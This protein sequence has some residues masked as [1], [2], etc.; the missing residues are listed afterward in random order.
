[1]SHTIRKLCLLFYATVSFH[2]ISN[3]SGL[4]VEHCSMPNWFIWPSR[5]SQR[6]NHSGPGTAFS[7]SAICDFSAMYSCGWRQS[8]F[9]WHEFS[10]ILWSPLLSYVH[11][12][13]VFLNTL[14]MLESMWKYSSPFFVKI[15]IN[16]V[17]K[18]CRCFEKFHISTNPHFACIL[19]IFL[20]TKVY[21]LLAKPLQ[22][23]F[24]GYIL[25]NMAMFKILNFERFAFL[26]CKYK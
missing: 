12:W 18:E 16:H 9:D 10:F 15:F 5:I 22:T 8:L 25:K 17:L 14:A 13:V 21:S 20:F 23:K 7:I 3:S 19:I 24:G 26:L 6:T 11:T 4:Q 2:H 1:M